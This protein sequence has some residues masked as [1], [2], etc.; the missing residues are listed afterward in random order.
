MK[1]LNNLTIAEFQDFV[2]LISV[3]KNPDVFGILS[4]F[5]EDASN[6]KFDEFNKKWLQIQSMT[7]TPTGVKKIYKIGDKRFEATLNHFNITAAQFIDLQSALESGKLEEILSCI[8]IPQRKKL[9]MWKTYKYNDGYD[10]NEVR[11]HL[12]NT[13]TIGEANSLSAFFLKSS[14]KLLKV[15]KDYLEN[16]EVR[17]KKKKLKKSLN[18]L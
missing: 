10:M 6:M 14:T 7:L 8:L 17:M 18:N 13:F 16:K 1:N 3:K 12:L 9:F 5:G 4:I 15:T 11:D 2:N